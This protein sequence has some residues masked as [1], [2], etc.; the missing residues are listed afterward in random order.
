MKNTFDFVIETVKNTLYSDSEELTCIKKL[1]LSIYF[2]GNII[3][4]CST[5]K[6]TNANLILWTLELWSCVTTCVLMLPY[7][8]QMLIFLRDK[9]SHK[10]REFAGLR[11]HGAF[12]SPFFLRKNTRRR[13]IFLLTTFLYHVYFIIRM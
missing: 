3:Y 10:R 2:Y 4:F 1:C 9:T 8:M 5:R 12:I 11:A 7:A 6:T 13:R